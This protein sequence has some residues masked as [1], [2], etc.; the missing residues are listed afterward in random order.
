MLELVPVDVGTLK[1]SQLLVG[2]P[3]FLKVVYRVQGSQEQVSYSWQP[4][5]YR[6]N[7]VLSLSSF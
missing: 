1:R 2:L 4:H 5:R 3:V 6:K 7:N